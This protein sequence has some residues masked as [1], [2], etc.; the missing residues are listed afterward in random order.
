MKKMK[1]NIVKRI[2]PFLVITLVFAAFAMTAFATVK[3]YTVNL[4]WQQ[5]HITC[6]TANKATTATY[7]QH[8]VTN[9]GGDFDHIVSWCDAPS[10]VTGGYSIYEGAGYVTMSYNSVPSVGTYLKA[11]AHNGTWSLVQVS[12]SGTVDFK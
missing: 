8:K 3:N 5:A 9:L 10:D 2:V 11:R 1:K 6:A 4:P 7:L 12:C